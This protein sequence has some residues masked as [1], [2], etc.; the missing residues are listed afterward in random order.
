MCMNAL[1]QT[2]DAYQKTHFK[3][4]AAKNILCLDG[5]YLS[6][7]QWINSGRLF[8]K[9]NLNYCF[10]LRL[11]L[12]VWYFLTKHCFLCFADLT[13]ET[14][15]AVCSDCESIA[16]E[17]MHT[18]LYIYRNV[19]IYIYMYVLYMCCLAAPPSACPF[20]VFPLMLY[21]L[22]GAGVSLHAPY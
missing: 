22:S 2:R 8:S 1:N 17:P 6:S 20:Q 19:C 10:S 16:C 9:I 18:C 12:C 15:S 7:V 3:H 4:S 14:L 21:I 5:N 11:I 13:Q